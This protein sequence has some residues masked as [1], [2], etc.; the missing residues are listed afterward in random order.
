LLERV[1]GAGVDEDRPVEFA[2]AIRSALADRQEAEVKK[3]ITHVFQAVRIEVNQEFSAL[4]TLLRVIPFCLAPGGRVAIL[5]FLSGED[6]RVKK[7]FQAGH[8]EGVYSAVA[9]DVIRATPAEC[10]SNLRATPA[11]LRWARC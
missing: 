7:A 6:R 3:S 4:D 11:K 5:T 2:S 1:Y 8:R 9:S 10:R